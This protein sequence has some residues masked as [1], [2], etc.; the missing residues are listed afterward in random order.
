MIDFDE[1]DR[2]SFSLDACRLV[3]GGESLLFGV[4]AG[5][6]VVFCFS[7]R[8][9]DWD[10]RDLLRSPVGEGGGEASVAYGEPGMGA[11]G[12]PRSYARGEACWLWI[13][14]FSLEE[15]RFTVLGLDE[16]GLGW[17]EVVFPRAVDWVRRRG[18]C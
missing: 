17:E 11:R 10:V 9:D 4:D 3:F 16:V 5:F 18:L 15:E 1:R 2:S 7:C 13:L 8:E 12:C 6:G 14:Y